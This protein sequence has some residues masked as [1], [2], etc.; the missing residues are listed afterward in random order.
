MSTIKKECIV[1]MLTATTQHKGSF[2]VM[3]SAEMF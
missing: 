2:S 1:V 3:P